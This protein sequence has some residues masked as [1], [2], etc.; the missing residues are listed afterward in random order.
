MNIFELVKE[1]TGEDF[2][3]Y[4]S[5]PSFE[6]GME[7]GLVVKKPSP[8]ELM[9]GECIQ[10]D[11]EHTVVSESGKE[12]KYRVMGLNAFLK[13]LLFG[14]NFDVFYSVRCIGQLDMATSSAV[15]KK[16]IDVV[17][18]HYKEIVTVINSR[19]YS[20]S[21]ISDF[22][23]ISGAGDV[24]YLLKRGYPKG[25]VADEDV[26]RYN[27]MIFKTE[28]MKSRLYDSEIKYS[29]KS[30]D[31]IEADEIEAHSKSYR[32]TFEDYR[33]RYEEYMQKEWS[34]EVSEWVEA[35]LSLSVKLIAE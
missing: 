31:E 27:E 3:G 14:K 20:G 24:L 2:L 22:K 34:E 15:F 21:L 29:A 11:V 5:L 30:Y 10:D 23:R 13:E 26:A 7:I 33:E 6:K 16:L 1:Q 19:N 8:A 12:V 17:T 25:R 4:L 35:L 18:A 28:V 9:F 32:H